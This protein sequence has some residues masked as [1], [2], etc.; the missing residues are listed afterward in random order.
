MIEKII[1]NWLIKASE[2]SYQLP[3]CYLLMQQG[4]T[5]LHMT[6][7]SAME[8]G[9]DIIALDQ[10]GVPHA[11]QLK[12]INGGRLTISGWQ[13]IQQQITQLALTP[14]KHPSILNTVY[15][16]SYL[17]VNGDI[18]E[19]VQH[20]ISAFNDDWEKRGFPQYHI[21]TI[22]KGQILEMA[23]EAKELFIP[24]EATDFKT[25][26]EFYLE[27][28]I[29]FLDKGKFAGMMMN[30][31]NGKQDLG[32]TERRRI[33]SSGALLCSLATASYTKTRNH[34]AKIEAW[35]IYLL[36]IFHAIEKNGIN[37]SEF[38][39]EI[40][41]TK[42]IITNALTDL[43]EEVK[44]SHHLY[45]GN[46]LTDAFVATERTTLIT[47]YAALLAVLSPDDYS[48]QVNN[49]LDK[50][51]PSTGL[52]GESAIPYLLTPYF[53]FRRQEQN[54]KADQLLSDIFTRTIL[55]IITP[56]VPFP[57]IYTSAEQ[58]VMMAFTGIDNSDG[59]PTPRISFVLEPLISLLSQPQ[60]RRVMEEHW[61][62]IS[63]CVFSS[64]KL[65]NSY[66]FYNWRIPG[67]EHVNRYPQSPQSWTSLLE[68]GGH[69]DTTS[70]PSMLLFD[71][72]WAILFLM[73][74]PHRL[75]G[76]LVKWIADT[77]DIET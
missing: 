72:K 61:P 41:L 16:K 63:K 65:D 26:L 1:E 27:D 29:G 69:V 8:Q 23:F 49:F 21:H 33:I 66:D 40:E 76:E 57:D 52:W 7:H 59:P 43:F 55:T 10:E 35:S 77:N 56:D 53:L 62:E 48:D 54:T 2:K 47:G 75:N 18:D 70:L 71:K 20:A 17:V 22:V 25:L 37:K 11:Y 30:L 64:V 74:F 3:F 5:I 12:G 44:D 58:A 68:Q 31:F 34:V 42:E 24:S 67:G 15:H 51:L 46:L 19:E 36:C 9:K 4:K 14:C 28:G 73:V 13:E 38:K 39:N 50:F 6:R 32:K 60:F 45:M